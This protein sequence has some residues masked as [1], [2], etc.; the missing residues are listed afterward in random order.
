M[1]HHQATDKDL[2]DNTDMV[3]QVAV[4]GLVVGLVLQELALVAREL[5]LVRAL[6]FLVADL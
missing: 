6:A 4:L 1:V 3:P 2:A 5:E